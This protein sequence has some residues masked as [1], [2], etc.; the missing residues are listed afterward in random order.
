MSLT[1]Q[2]WTF[3]PDNGSLIINPFE[4][5]DFG[6]YKVEAYWTNGSFVS[7]ATIKL[8]SKVFF[9]VTY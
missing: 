3:F 2:R 9:T 8:D 4:P 7:S 6:I 1:Q 5:A